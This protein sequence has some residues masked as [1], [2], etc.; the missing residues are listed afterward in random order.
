[1]FAVRYA[2]LEIADALVSVT[3]RALGGKPPH[4][5][6]REPHGPNVCSIP[7]RSTEAAGEML[8]DILGSATSGRS[9]VREI[10]KK[11]K[12]YGEEGC[13][14][15]RFFLGV[16][17]SAPL[18][19]IVFGNQYTRETNV[20]SGSQFRDSNSTCLHAEEKVRLRDGRLAKYR[21]Y[22]EDQR[23]RENG[24]KERGLLVS[25][26]DISIRVRQK[27][28]QTHVTKIAPAMR[29]AKKQDVYI[30][31]DEGR[32]VQMDSDEQPVAETEIGGRASDY[33]D[34]TRCGEINKFADSRLLLRLRCRPE[35]TRRTM[36]TC[37]R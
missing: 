17:E 19:D 13:Q 27:R 23:R 21:Q 1:M 24:C 14:A 8:G 28:L 35:S 25:F 32:F 7:T 4:P 22:N 34:V 16:E 6:A 31:H 30:Q 11:N 26:G 10:E 36:M 18:S 37:L 29:A 3:R 2:Y 5:T 15:N 9:D 12:T 20:T 33:P